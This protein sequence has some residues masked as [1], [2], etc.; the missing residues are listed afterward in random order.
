MLLKVMLESNESYVLTDGEK[1][2]K[3]R[4]TQKLYK[5]KISLFLLVHGL[6]YTE[7]RNGGYVC[8]F[9]CLKITCWANASRKCF[10]RVHLD[11]LQQT[12][13]F[14]N[15]KNCPSFPRQI[16]IVCSV[17][18]NSYTLSI[19]YSYV[20]FILHEIIKC[21]KIVIKSLEHS[22]Q[23]IKC[24]QVRLL[25][26]CFFLRPLFNSGRF[27]FYWESILSGVSNPA[28]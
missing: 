15:L 3:S 11:I 9:V 12:L 14:N 16:H 27:P 17:S 5:Q 10:G 7:Q 2:R 23:K 26:F 24:Y 19:F 1:V 22:C 28:C 4:T 21:F 20:K 6:Y 13:N 8:L 25:F 18:P